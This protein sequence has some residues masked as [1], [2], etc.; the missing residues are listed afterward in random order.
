MSKEYLVK[1]TV[2]LPGLRAY[3]LDKLKECGFHYTLRGN[4]ID[5]S[6]QGVLEEIIHIWMMDN[7][8]KIFSITGGSIEEAKKLGYIP[9]KSA[10][11]KKVK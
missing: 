10:A 2:H 3:F 8:D 1:L 11:K 4:K 6:N 5:N 7:M 9:Y